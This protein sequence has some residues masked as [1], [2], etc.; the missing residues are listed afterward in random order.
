MGTKNIPAHLEQTGA[1]G[2][3]KEVDRFGF[4]HG[5]LAREGEWVYSV[6][7]CFVAAAQQTLELG[8]DSRAPCTRTFHLGH[9]VFEERF[10]ELR[11]CSNPC[12]R[13]VTSSSRCS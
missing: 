11:H 10:V 6:Q 5:P 7:R 13:T 8:Y 1:R 9:A 12:G 2:V 3:E 4:A